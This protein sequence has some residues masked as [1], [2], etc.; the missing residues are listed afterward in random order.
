MWVYN[1]RSLITGVESRG[2]LS[3]RDIEM[4]RERKMWKDKKDDESEQVE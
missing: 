2:Q 1:E 4:G 3:K